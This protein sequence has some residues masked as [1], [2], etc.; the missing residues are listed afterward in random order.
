MARYAFLGLSALQVLVFLPMS[1]AADSQPKEVTL[2]VNGHS[3]VAQ[4]IRVNGKSYIDLEGLARVGNGTLGFH[5]SEIT[6][7]LPG[8][9][10][11]P[12]AAA[13]QADP[14]AKP[15]LSAAFMKAGIEQLAAIREWRVTLVN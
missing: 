5:Q 6:L 13:G 3:G 9:G 11:A 15:R 10:A 1:R 12:A 4:V 14:S 8:R 7:T 2:S